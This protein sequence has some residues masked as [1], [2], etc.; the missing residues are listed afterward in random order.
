MIK[1]ISPSFIVLASFVLSCATNAQTYE[2]VKTTDHWEAY[3]SG[4]GKGRFCFVGSEPIKKKGAYTRRDKTYVLVTH[5]PNDKKN[6]VDIFELVAGY[7]YKKDSGVTIKIG[8]QKFELFTS[9]GT[10]WAKSSKTDRALARAMKRGNTMT[11]GGTSSRGTKTLDTYS[12]KGFT[13]AYNAIGNN[14][15]KK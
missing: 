5:R 15:K 1:I 11:V 14:C 3:K 4:S 10:A 12:L 7:T 2:K 9:G 6:K 8:S 13:A